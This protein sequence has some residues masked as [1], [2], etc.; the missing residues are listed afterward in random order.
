MDPRAAIRGGRPLEEHPG[1]AIARGLEG[2]LEQ[3]LLGPARE[4]LAL[5]LVRRPFGREEGEAHLGG[6]LGGHIRSSTPR[7]TALK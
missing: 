3:P 4:Q 5:Q 1:L 2:A 7:T 6:G